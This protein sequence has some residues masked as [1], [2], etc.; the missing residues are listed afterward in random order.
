MSENIY[1]VVYANDIAVV[2]V[3][4]QME[5]NEVIKRVT[6]WMEKCRLNPIVQKT[7]ML[8]LITK[9]IDSKITKTKKKHIML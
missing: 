1:I 4:G 5:L 2:I 9:R 3:Q 8:L 7:I 6:C